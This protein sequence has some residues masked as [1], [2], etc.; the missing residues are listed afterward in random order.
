MFDVSLSRLPF[1]SV[2]SLR[3]TTGVAF[4]NS[5]GQTWTL[6]FSVTFSLIAALKTAIVGRTV[7][8]VGPL[9]HVQLK[10]RLPDSAVGDL[11]EFFSG[12]RDRKRPSIPRVSGQWATL[13]A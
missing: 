1:G 5:G 9:P 7:A 3:P 6:F 12:D 10:I 2:R 13:A 8:G 4:L 11:L